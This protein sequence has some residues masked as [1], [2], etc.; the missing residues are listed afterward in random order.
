[1]RDFPGLGIE[2][3]FLAFAVR[4]L[5]TGPPGMYLMFFL[6]KEKAFS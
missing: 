4:V 3:V 5:T 1:M 2:L 6:S